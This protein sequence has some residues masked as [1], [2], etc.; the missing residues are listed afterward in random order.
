MELAR[1]AD[2]LDAAGAMA[3]WRGDLEGLEMPSAPRPPLVV[4]DEENRPQPSLDL[5]TGDG[6]TVVVGRV[7]RCPVLG[8]KFVL[9]SHNA[10]R[11]AAGC[12]VLNAEY[13][14]ARDLLPRR[15]AR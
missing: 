12:T 7:R 10:V 9:L 5:D 4:R 11:G 2:P 13:L 8:L 3:R 14:A 6:M 15:P 1:H